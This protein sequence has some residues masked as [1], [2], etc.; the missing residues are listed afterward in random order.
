MGSTICA[1]CKHYW[2]RDVHVGLG[3]SGTEYVCCATVKRRA[4]TDPVFG[5]S[6]VTVNGVVSCRSR[7]GI[8][9][10]DLY[11]RASSVDKF[12][13]WLKGGLRP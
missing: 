5:D 10:C 2:A 1:N 9:A 12:I 3:E 8:G 6:M 11:E 7:N 13:N 4:T